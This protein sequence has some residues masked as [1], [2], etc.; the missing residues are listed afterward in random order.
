M[1]PTKEQQEALD[2]I[3]SWHKREDSQTFVLA[4]L[5]GTGKTTMIPWVYDALGASSI[6]LVA[7]TW[8]AATNL[9]RKM[10]DAGLKTRATSIHSLVYDYVG[11]KHD[12]MCAAR[13]DPDEEGRTMPCDRG[14]EDPSF[15]FREKE[16]ERGLIVV[17]E[18]SMV[19]ERMRGDLERLGRPVLYVGDH[20]QLPPVQ[21]TNV[22]TDRAPDARLETIN[23]QGNDPA[24]LAIKD[25]AH[26]IRAQDS[27]WKDYAMEA[28]FVFANRGGYQLD[29]DAIATGSE[30]LLA[31]RNVTVD[32]LN[33]KARGFLGRTEPLEVGDLVIFR[34]N[35]PQKATFNGQ[36]GEV[37][38]VKGE[39]ARIQ[40][41]NGQTWT[42]R[43]ALSPSKLSGQR[44]REVMRLNYGYALTCHRAQGS[45]YDG[46][47]VTVPEGYRTDWNWLY[48]AVTR[49]RSSVVFR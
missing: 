40:K 3:E 41:E 15:V 36:A 45:E 9:T 2:R 29:R 22:F 39:H 16:F 6:R 46:V 20:G 31:Y 7:P 48:T 34:D 8:K 32:D 1:E 25:L 11:V 49:A 47:V 10:E 5:A 28:G 14:C 35:Q 33:R 43:W 44:D 38:M 4:G 24:G 42:G 26:R 17:D 21:G 13:M 30:V 12:K 19:D 27:G 18:A 37:T 23:R